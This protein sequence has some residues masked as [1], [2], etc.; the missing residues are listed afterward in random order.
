MVGELRQLWPSH[1]CREFLQALPLLDFQQHTVPQL[2]PLSRILRW[3]QGCM[4]H[5]SGDRPQDL[6]TSPVTLC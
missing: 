2:E 5:R 6:L 1:A 4:F 3:A